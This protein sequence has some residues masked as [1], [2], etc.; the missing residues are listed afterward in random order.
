MERFEQLCKE[1]EGKIN[2]KD[3][4][5]HVTK[6]WAQTMIGYLVDLENAIQ[7]KQ[8]DD[9]QW[10]AF[11]GTQPDSNQAKGDTAV[12]AILKLLGLFSRKKN[13]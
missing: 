10:I 8:Q 11:L 12:K 5:L 9:G 6:E 4:T 3:N 1:L 2:Q 7:V 13:D